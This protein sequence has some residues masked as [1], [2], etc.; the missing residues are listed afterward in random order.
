V[1]ALAKGLPIVTEEWV[2]ASLCS[3]KW[4]KL[5][6]YFH[7]KYVP[8]MP[9]NRNKLLEKERLLIVKCSSPKSSV[10][11]S[12]IS[13]CGGTIVSDISSASMVLFGL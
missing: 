7:P 12:L 8:N 9:M 11:S 4:E 5:A 2:Y 10:I 6:H 3:E 1:F 13:L